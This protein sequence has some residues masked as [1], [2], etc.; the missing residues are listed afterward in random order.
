MIV[1]EKLN[2]ILD[3]LN[4]AEKEQM[5]L[6]LAFY[7]KT[8]EEMR[9]DKIEN[10]KF[11]LENQAKFYNQNPKKVGETILLNSKLYEILINKVTFMYDSILEDILIYKQ[12]ILNNQKILVGN[13]IY[14]SQ[15]IEETCEEDEKTRYQ[16]EIDSMFEKNK[17]FEE[18]LTELD[19]KIIWLNED[20]KKYL[21]ETFINKNVQLAV[22][23]TFMNKT[24]RGIKNLF[25]GK[26][27][28]RSV[29]SSYV[30]SINNLT[31]KIYEKEVELAKAS[32]SIKRFVKNSKKRILSVS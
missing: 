15:K 29:N 10:E 7:N 25:L 16:R 12:N 2:D 24:I 27:L 5:Y 30:T 4:K 26:R 8:K 21:D 9:E 1:L 17:Q 20:M 11:F 14:Y 6:E 32:I 18:L 22:N 19:Q 31:K 28:F 23:D 3:K 13:I